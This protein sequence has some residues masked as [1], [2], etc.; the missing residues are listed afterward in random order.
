MSSE[1]LDVLLSFHLAQANLANV[2]N[3]LKLIRGISALLTVV[4]VC[5]GT[6]TVCCVAVTNGMRICLMPKHLLLL[7]L[8]FTLPYLR[9]GQVVTPA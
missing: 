1:G 7:A 2:L 5:V 9:G 4:T 3:T 8:F 6:S